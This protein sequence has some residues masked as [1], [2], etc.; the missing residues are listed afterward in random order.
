[1]SKYRYSPIFWVV[2]ALVLCFGISLSI[3]AFLP[4][5]NIFVGDWI[6]FSGVDAYYH[7]RL[8][9]NLVHNFPNLSDFDPY[10]IYP[11]GGSVS[12]LHFS[13][14]LL[15]GLIW[16]IGLGAPTHHII[17]VVGVY[18]PAIL[19]ALTVIPVYFI[20]KELFGRRAGVIAAGLIAILPGEFLGRS[21]LGFTDHHIAE[22]LFTA[23]AMMFLILA[24]KTANQRQLTFN[25]LGYRYRAKSAKPIF[26]SLLTGIFLGI[27]LI[28]WGGGLL[29]VFLISAYLIIQFIIDYLKNKSTDYLCIVGVITFLIALVIYVS[30]SRS[31][32]DLVAIVIAIFIPVVLSAISRLM[33]YKK[34]KPTYFPLILFTLGVAGLGLFYLFSPSLL[35]SMMG[36]FTIFTPAGTQLATMEMQPMLFPQ[37]QFTFQIA[38]GNFTSSFFISLL[39]LGF[40]IYHVIKNGYPEKNLLIV[41]S[42]IILF[43]TLGQRRF[44]YYLAVNVA[45]LTGYALREQFLPV[46]TTWSTQRWLKIALPTIM[47]IFFFLYPVFTPWVVSISVALL[48]SYIIW[49]IWPNIIKARFSRASKYL[50]WGLASLIFLLVFYPNLQMALPTAATVRF[51]PSDAWVSSLTWMRENT[52]DPF[53]NPAQYYYKEENNKY[54]PL[55]WLKRNIPN[56]S[57]DPNFHYNL[58]E[59]YKYPDSAYGVTTWWDYG[60]WITRIA[61]RIPSANP[62]QDP[63][64]V[65]SVAKFFTSQ[66]EE[67]ARKIM[68]ELDSSYIV[69][70]YNTVSGKFWA[71]A[72]WAEQDISQFNDI[73]LIPRNENELVPIQL[74]LPE[75]YRSLL[76]RLYNFDGKAV[77]PENSTVIAYEPKITKEGQS[78]KVITDVQVFPNYEEAIAFISDQNSGNYQIVSDNPFVSPVPLKSL[79]N[80]R[81]I[82]NSDDTVALQYGVSVPEVKIFEYVE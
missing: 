23:I 3:R 37:G 36:L 44:A 67:S 76:I 19:G 38:L 62:G 14:W 51:A 54:L 72:L 79:E 45:L 43:A 48:I 7:M 41:W 52:P 69:I 29:L 26:Y 27:Y 32:L 55:Y 30:V 46:L 66:D 9:D 78:V 74:F 39:A 65:T 16:I 57:G 12:S 63:M 4:Y 2:I 24:I 81:L 61:H 75:Y 34:L 8:I 50:N 56:P 64:P 40:L 20:G 73:Y 58:D 82:Y 42:L 17:D 15:A 80:Y 49:Q 31:I 22:T 25:H 10:F 11:G 59:S 77:I 5:D 13:D 1:M 70:D 18:Y 53:G 21:V 35:N 33:A 28:T 68:Q 71:V 60:Y 6:K 47:I